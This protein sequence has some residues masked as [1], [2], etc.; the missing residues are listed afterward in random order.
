MGAYFSYLCTKTELNR[1]S[2]YFDDWQTNEKYKNAEISP[3]LLWDFDRKNFDWHESRSA[4]VAR[5]IKRGTF[6]DVYAA[7]RLY[8]GL[9]NYIKIIRDEVRGLNSRDI[10]YVTTVFHLKEDDLLSVK[11][12]R[13]REKVI[14]KCPFPEEEWF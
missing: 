5:V 14:G 9:D 10:A 12:K 7:I 2:M 3:T 8:G 4:V 11:L 6:A 1:L 13:E